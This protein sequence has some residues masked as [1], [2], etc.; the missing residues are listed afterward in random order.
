MSGTDEYT[1]IDIC[2]LVGE[3]REAQIRSRDFS[4]SQTRQQAHDQADTPFAVIFDIDSTVMNTE[5]RNLAILRE[6]AEI[7]PEFAPSY[8]RIH[9]EGVGWNIVEALERV[10]LEDKTL[11]AQAREFWHARFFTDDYVFHDTPYPGAV[12]CI[13]QLILNGFSILFVTGRDAPGMRRGTLQH[14]ADHGIQEGSRV[15]F[16]FKPSF[17]MA[18]SEFKRKFCREAADRYTITATIENEPRNANMFARA[19]PDALHFWIDTITSPHREPLRPEV[20]RFSRY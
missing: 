12:A 10:G 8:D 13:N 4:R 6:L 1:K 3:N 9:R 18:D 11:L 20:I 2:R 17:K 7:N 5:P 16:F 19:F 15:R 14:F